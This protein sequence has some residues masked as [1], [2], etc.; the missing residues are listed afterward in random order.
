MDFVSGYLCKRQFKG[1]HDLFIKL[2]CMVC[3]NCMLLVFNQI[4]V[5]PKATGCECKVQVQ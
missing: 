4:F 3:F 5:C 1:T 2:L